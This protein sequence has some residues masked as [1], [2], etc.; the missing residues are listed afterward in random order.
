MRP[1]DLDDGRR[2]GSEA[3]AG[4]VI[5]LDCVRAQW[6]ARGLEA[7][8]AMAKDDRTQVSR[9]VQEGDGTAGRPASVSEI[10]DSGGEGDRS[11]EICR[12]GL[13]C[14]DGSRGVKTA[15]ASRKDIDG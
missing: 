6:Q 7:R 9:A 3:L 4:R 5:G 2:A 11:P 8:L 12:P 13:C 10:L 15:R 14:Q 1:D